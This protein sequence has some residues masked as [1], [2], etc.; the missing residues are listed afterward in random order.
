M[1]AIVAKPYG[2]ERNIKDRDDLKVK[3]LEQKIL[4]EICKILNENFQ[5]NHKN[6]FWKIIVG[7]WLRSTLQ[8]LLN[9]I[10]TLKQCLQLEE[11]SGTTVYNSN[12]SA[13]AIPHLRAGFTYF[14]DNPKWNNI[15]IGRILTL[16]NNNKIP[17][18]FIDDNN[19]VYSYK[20]LETND[21]NKK[22]VNKK[23][24]KNY[25]YQGYKKI[26]EKLVR[27]KDAFLI[28]TYINSKQLAKLE[29]NLGQ[30]P[31]FWKKIEVNINAKP[32]QSLRKRLTK[33][34]LKKSEDDLEN[35]LRNLLFELL[36]V[37]HLEGF[38]ELK[39]IVN[40]QPWPKK[41]KFIFTSNNFGTDEI[42]KLYT[43]IKTENGS[44]Y[45]VGQHGN[46]YFTGRYFFPRVEEQTADKFLTW[47]WESKLSK[48]IPMYI[49]KTSGVKSKYNN[50]GKLL[51]VERP[52]FIRRMPWDTHDEFTDYFEDQKNFVREL[53][54]DPK[55][56]LLIR[57]SASNANIN[58]NEISRWHDFDKTLIIDDGK[59]RLE[60]LIADSRLVIHSYDTTGFLENLSLNIPTMVF[61]QNGFDHLRDSVKSDYQILVDAGLVYFSSKSISKKVNEVWDNVDQ[62]WSQKKVQDAKVF[63]SN[64]YAKSSKNP[65]KSLISFFK[66]YNN[67]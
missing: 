36:P 27:N 3:Y 52:Q 15:L 66:N 54:Q 30:L 37:C 44:K 19:E 60:K 40:K 61:W 9:R 8:L 33:K 50:K 12:Y 47:G 51:L 26:A 22:H 42:F 65:T 59:T 21:T 7:T 63:F 4:P 31:Q 6:R 48:Y 2:L 46:N 64:K 17:I 10:N 32:N 57:L 23:N 43:A 18:N 1:D 41:P 11:I 38:E 35:V 55:K 45:Y 14:F 49:F 5:T 53:S 67:Y 13:L 20:V 29:I 24:I 39:K 56:N 34:L 16:I 25:I 62:W 58:L 28:N